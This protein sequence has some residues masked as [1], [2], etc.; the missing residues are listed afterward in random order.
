VQKI[1]KA[2]GTLCKSFSRLKYCGFGSLEWH[3][4]ERKAGGWPEEKAT[5]QPEL[6]SD[7]RQGKGKGRKG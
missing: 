2:G 6:T 5:A 1:L 7:S 4:Q 3:G